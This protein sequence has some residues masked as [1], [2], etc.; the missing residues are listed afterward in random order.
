MRSIMHSINQSLSIVTGNFEVT[1]SQ[2][3]TAYLFSVSF[4]LK[5]IP[6]PECLSLNEISRTT[7]TLF[8]AS[9]CHCVMIHNNVVYLHT[10]IIHAYIHIHC[11]YITS[12]IHTYMIHAYIQIHTY[13]HTYLPTCL[14]IYLHTCIHTYIHI[15]TYIHTYT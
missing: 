11:T 13:I 15:C 5:I 3:Y 8:S 14:P 4:I 9:F 6:I 1:W 12:Y 2:L 7:C 10:Y